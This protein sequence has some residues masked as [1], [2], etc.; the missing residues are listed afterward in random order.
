MVPDQKAKAWQMANRAASALS[1]GWLSPA[2]LMLAEV[3]LG[4]HQPLPLSQFCQMAFAD[5]PDKRIH[6]LCLVAFDLP[7][8]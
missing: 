4:W 8:G 1:P 2:T 7:A 5:N 6:F 3:L